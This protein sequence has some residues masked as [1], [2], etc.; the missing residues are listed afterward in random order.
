LGIDALAEWGEK[1]GLASKTNIELP[2]EVTG[3]IG[4][5]DVLYD[6]T[7]SLDAQNTSL[8]KLVLRSLKTLLAS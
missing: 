6:N 2:S 3:R 5:Q 1:L 8:P 4:G 7:K